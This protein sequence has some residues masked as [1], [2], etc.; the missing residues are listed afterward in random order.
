MRSRFDEQLEL[1]NKELLEMGALIEHAIKSASQALLTQDVD[2]ANKAIEFDKEVDQKEKDIESL[3]LRLL[4]QQQPVARDLRQ[5]SAALK[6]ITDMERIGDQAADISGIVI[7]LAGT[8]Y[9]KRLEHLPQMADAAIRMVKGSI[10][11][12]VRKDLALTK[13][14]I[15]MDDIIDNLF[16]IVKNELIERIH[17]KAENGEQAIDLL[18]V[19]KYFERIG[20]HAQNIAEWVEFSITGKHKGELI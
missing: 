8:P 10:D 9:I 5:I 7:Y 18:M 20:D 19:A 4:L 11:A 12:Y 13:E 3:C 1:L 16:V 6:M 14:I 2:A 17:E 15:D